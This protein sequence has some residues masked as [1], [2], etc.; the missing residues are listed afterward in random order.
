MNSD[1]PCWIGGMLES[2][3]GA[4]HCL[5][6]ATLPNIKYPSDIFPTSRFYEK[7]IA[8]PPMIL[9]SPGEFYAR[10]E[11]G[12]GAEP[13]PKKFEKSIIERECFLF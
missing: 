10:M 2:P 11:P 13:D 1:I 12:I 5:A 4:N 7:D 3:I 8:D 6:L 9:S